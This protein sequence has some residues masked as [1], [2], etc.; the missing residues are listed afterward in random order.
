MPTKRARRLPARRQSDR[1]PRVLCK[2]VDGHDWTFMGGPEE[3]AWDL[4]ADA[5]EQFGKELLHGYVF[6]FPPGALPGNYR[7]FGRAGRPG[8]RP[9]AWWQFDAPELRRVVS[10]VAK[11][12]EELGWP[13]RERYAWANY[14]G[15]PHSIYVPGCVYETQQAYLERLGLLLSGEEKL[16]DGM[17]PGARGQGGSPARANGPL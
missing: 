9:W 1:S 14:F 17:A 8:S 11:S 7:D 5:W 12:L 6:G 4:L 16:L 13:L 10:G 3:L 2:L 15:Q